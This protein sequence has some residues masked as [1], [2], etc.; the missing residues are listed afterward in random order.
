MSEKAD[1]S[2]PIAQTGKPRAKINMCIQ[3]LGSSNTLHWDRTNCT[4]GKSEGCQSRPN[5]LINRKLSGPEHT[6]MCNCLPV[7]GSVL[8]HGCKL[9]HVGNRGVSSAEGSAP[10]GSTRLP[11]L[12]SCGRHANVQGK[13]SGFGGYSPISGCYSQLRPLRSYS[14]FL[15]LFPHRKGTVNENSFCGMLGTEPAL[16]EHL[17]NG[18]Q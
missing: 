9:G 17:A 16:T 18:N 10:S 13:S 12:P 14:S 7:T 6:S 5:F 8:L 15:G 2:L 3:R 11:L 1:I 4:P